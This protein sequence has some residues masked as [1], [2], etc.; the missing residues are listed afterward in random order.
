M[1][2]YLPIPD[3]K[4]EN[5]KPRDAGGHAEKYSN[6]RKPLGASSK[7][8]RAIIELPQDIVIL[9]L[10]RIATKKLVNKCL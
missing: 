8:Y 3:L 9:L 1:D 5:R 2:H 7:H 6:L 4:K 10:R